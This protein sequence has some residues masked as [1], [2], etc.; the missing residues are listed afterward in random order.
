M[1]IRVSGMMSG[2]DTDSI[3]KDLTSAYSAKKDTYVKAQKLNT[4]KQDQWKE[5][6]KKV[7]GFYTRS[8]STA[9]IQ[10]NLKTNSFVSS[11]SAI[12]SNVNSKKEADIRVQQLAT[13]SYLSGSKIHTE[14]WP[15]GQDTSFEISVGGCDH[16]IDI[17]ADMT[18]KDVA[19]K[20]ADVGLESNFDEK[21]GRL[22]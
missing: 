16:T 3:V 9:R 6:N 10:G 22:F 7:Y 20:L 1:A 2:L 15:I 12:V 14:D 17:T 11:D 13:K 4:I 18:I 5:I 19:K 8:L 21:T